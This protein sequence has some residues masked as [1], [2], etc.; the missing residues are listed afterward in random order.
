MAIILG[1]ALYPLKYQFSLEIKRL[2]FFL[3]LSSHFSYFFETR[4][5]NF[6]TV[7]N[8]LNAIISGVR[9]GVLVNRG[10]YSFSFQI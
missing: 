1:V 7:T 8:V 5:K 6:I 10:V 9:I 3:P 2:F 4:N